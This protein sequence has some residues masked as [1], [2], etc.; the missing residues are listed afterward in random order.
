[1]A[2]KVGVSKTPPK[3]EARPLGK[4]APPKPKA[5]KA[6]PMPPKEPESVVTPDEEADIH[7][8]EMRISEATLIDK[9]RSTVIEFLMKR[10]EMDREIAE[11][12]MQG[13]EPEQIGDLWE[14][15][16]LAI[17]GAKHPDAATTEVSIPAEP[18]EAEVPDF[19]E[20]GL[21][22]AEIVVEQDGVEE[23]KSFAQ[24][25]IECVEAAQAKVANE[26]VYKERK[27]QIMGMMA[28]AGIGRNEPIAA[29]GN[30]LEQY[31]G[32][33]PKQLDSLKLVEKGVSIDIIN[34]CYKQ[35]EYDDVRI[36]IPK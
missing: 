20:V 10:D 22:E 7:E 24:L 17:N 21:G 25:V 2:K 26:K 35:T 6:K 16:Q 34:K 9:R 12:V 36:T 28:A 8:R 13:L 11:M 14:E 18:N 32:K 4:P 15:A 23:T 1:M 3:S 5:A 29:F 19:T 27:A 31:R 33:T 30:K